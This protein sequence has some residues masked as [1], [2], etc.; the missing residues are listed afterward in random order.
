MASSLTRNVFIL[1]FLCSVLFGFSNAQLSTNFYG[2]SCRSLQTIV[3]NGMR[4][5]VNREARLGAS[6]LRLFFHDCFVNGCDAS[7]L[8]DDTATLTGEKNA[9]PNRN[10][11]RG[12]EEIDTI[13]T[14][15]EAACPNTVSCADILALAAREG[16]V[17]LGGPTWAVPLGRRDARTASQS[18]A[19]T[20]IPAPTSSLSTL[21]SMFSAKGLNARDM[22]ALSGSH[23]IGQARCTTF[24]NRIYNDT[25]IDPQFATTRRATCPASGGDANLAPLDIQTPSQFDNDYYQNLVARRGLLHSDQE[26]FNGG[27]QDA[28]VRSYST[29]GAAFTSDFA[30]AM[31][32]M[33]NISPLTG[34]NGEIRRNC[35]AIN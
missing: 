19:N 13:K 35:R 21:I 31:V 28:L 5:A 17:L 1:T 33:G 10:S 27:S 3:S 32:K 14:Q 8:L 11:A 29:N 16:V 6:I 25:N 4:Q 22:T 2:A 23:T 34:T 15:V 18:A 12:Y 24:R 26:L 20:Q 30:A 7:I 9:N